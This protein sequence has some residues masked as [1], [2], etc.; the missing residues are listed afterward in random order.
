MSWD[1]WVSSWTRPITIP[2][3]IGL[4]VGCDRCLVAVISEIRSD[5]N[6]FPSD[7]LV[8]NEGGSSAGCSEGYC[9]T[10]GAE[11][12]K[13]ASIR[14]FIMHRDLHICDF[15]LAM[16]QSWECGDFKVTKICRNRFNSLLLIMMYEPISSI[17]VRGALEMF[18][19]W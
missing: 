5:G 7:F 17:E 3:R 6:Q 9:A 1:R 10:W 12:S 19:L 14:Q 8:P 18:Y 2:N 4:P 15:K 13:V 16:R 11:V